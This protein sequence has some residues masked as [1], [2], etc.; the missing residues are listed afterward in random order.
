MNAK[1]LLGFQ[2][3]GLRGFTAL[4]NSHIEATQARWDVDGVF[5]TK[6][7]MAGSAPNAL[8][9]LG[10]SKAT[11]GLGHV[12]NIQSAYLQSALFENSVSI[13]YYV[14]LMYAE[15]PAGI[16]IN[17]L[18]GKPQFDS[19]V[20]EVGFQAAPNSVVDNGNG[21]MTMVI[22]SVTEVGVSNAGRVVRVWK[23]APADGGTTLSIALEEV[24]SVFTGGQ[25]KITTAAKFGQ[26]TISTVAADYLVTVM[27]PR[28]SRNT[29][30]SAVPGVVFIGTVVGNGAT[31]STFSN[32]N[33]TLLKTFQDATQVAY[34]PTGWLSPGATTVQ[35]ALDTIVSGLGDTVSTGTSGASKVG[36]YSAG[37]STVAT[38]GIGNAADS[39]YTAAATIADILIG[40]NTMARRRQSFQTKNDTNGTSQP[41]DDAASVDLAN[42][43]A[44]SR[45]QW[46]RALANSGTTPYTISSD[47]PA[48]P[49]QGSYFMGEFNDPTQ[50]NSHLRKTAIKITGS[51]RAIS[52]GKWQRVW[53]D[54]AAGFAA[55]FGGTGNIQAGILEDFGA[56][57]GAIWME[58]TISPTAVDAP[59]NWRNGVIKPKASESKWGGSS[60]VYG[61]T[62]SG[63][64]WHVMEKLLVYGN[65]TTQSGGAR[66]GA[67]QFSFRMDAPL[68]AASVSLQGRPL[69]Y[70]DCVFVCQDTGSQ[71]LILVEGTQQVTFDNCKFFDIAGR[72][73]DNPLFFVNASGAQVR[74][75]NCTFFSPEGR[76]LATN[77]SSGIHIDDC[78]FV[79]GIGGSSTLTA[80]QVLAINGGDT[81]QPST[82]RD[83][84]IYLGTAVFRANATATTTPLVAFYGTTVTVQ[85]LSVKVDSS[86]TDLGW[87]KILDVLVNSQTGQGSLGVFENITL[88]CNSVK[89]N[90]TSSNN[91]VSLSAS[92]TPD[93]SRLEVNHLLIRNTQ[94]NVSAGN[95]NAWVSVGNGVVG[96]DWLVVASTTLPTNKI[97][98]LIKISGNA[99]TLRDIKIGRARYA[100]SNNNGAILVIGDNNKISGISGDETFNATAGSGGA[101][102]YL[103][104]IVG[105]HN[106]LL[107]VDVT[108]GADS[109]AIA[110]FV[111]RDNSLCL[112]TLLATA[113]SGLVPVSFSSGR[114]C[115]FVNNTLHWNGTTN[116]G[117]NMTTLDSIID[118]VTIYRS[119]GASAGWSNAASGSVTGTCAI[120][121]TTL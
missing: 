14:G 54:A 119:A 11:D 96:T 90:A 1:Q 22:D 42:Q 64:V 62:N 53:I 100:M 27:G 44:T 113:A 118:D 46:L 88:D 97:G 56:N 58:P 82:I 111:G 91:V 75:K 15:I 105:N 33:Q 95:S 51:N 121:S 98:S 102:Q 61:N 87:A 49:G 109:N 12:L 63:W 39:T 89:A 16:R 104:S 106:A 101:T 9:I 52:L 80:P 34:A 86:A 93:S 67:I 2:D 41:A 55:R 28:I 120:L 30:L 108:M 71:G 7:S 10:S 45:P 115:R 50:A 84:R 107:E 110:N 37:Y 5:N 32:A 13:N 8:L 117:V 92:A 94:I 31:P 99:N 36:V 35:L 47:V 20:E 17:P 79:A 6:L 66:N 78:T 19:Y 18:T 40:I 114:R 76:C 65:D 103:L 21:T 23:V 38:G 73:I 116:V 112:S 3:L 77:Q 72:T 48:G 85:N 4:R 60:I 43:I 69:V 83:S 26:T 57:G 70:R 24:T 25:N 68:A 81:P 74:L 29:D 59:T